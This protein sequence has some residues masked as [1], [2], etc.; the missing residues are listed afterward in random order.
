MRKSVAILFTAAAALGVTSLASAQQRLPRECR[1]EIKQLC[2]SDRSK[3]RECLRD[4][5]SE[6]SST[7]QSELRERMQARRGDRRAPTQS[8]VITPDTAI[9]FGTH[10]RQQIDFYSAKGEAADDGNAPV[11]LFVHG[12]GWAMGDRAQA[13]HAKPA[14]YTANGVAFASTGYRLVPEV[15]V[16]EQAADIASAIAA[17]RGQADALGLDPDRIVLMGHS[18]GA[19]LAALVATD[20][21]YAGE[22]MAAIKGV[23]LL[24]GA[25][26]DLAKRMAENLDISSS[27]YRNAFGTDPAR[28]SALSPLTHVGA[29]DAPDWMI[30]FVANR[31]QSRA[32]SEALT[33][34]LR[35]A[36]A[37]A[38]ALPI[39]N[40]DHRRLN[41]ELGTPGDPATV[42]VDEFLVQLRD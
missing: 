4:K 33:L 41:T 13:V 7:C 28:Q 19:H 17:L 1:Q 9:M 35:E 27:L 40:T 2:G 22:D 3:I 12:G 8:A 16:E 31:E 14:H 29:P 37:K 18:A 25:G 26:Y 23:V 24:D 38:E 6:L 15:S 30:L 42:L 5:A 39:E 11:I 36:G 20:P 21:H 10:T 34:A 32:Q